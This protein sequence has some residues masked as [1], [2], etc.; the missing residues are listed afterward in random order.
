MYTQRKYVTYKHKLH[1]RRVS[2]QKLHTKT[3]VSEC[4]L[5]CGHEFCEIL[6]G[7]Y[8][9]ES[10]GRRE[11]LLRLPSCDKVQ[12]VKIHTLAIGTHV[13]CNIFKIENVF[14]DLGF[15]IKVSTLER[16]K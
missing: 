15:G 11:F 2:H 7:K 5:R 12:N 13:T 14:D 4:C 9:P 3:Y 1:T 6:R 16:I 10:G 8:K